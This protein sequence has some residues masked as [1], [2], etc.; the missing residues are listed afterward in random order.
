MRCVKKL[1]YMAHSQK[2]L[3]ETVHE[4]TQDIGLIRLKC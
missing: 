4:E 1:E 3:T 2:K